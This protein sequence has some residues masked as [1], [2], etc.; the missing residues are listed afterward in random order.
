MKATLHGDFAI[1]EWL[2]SPAVNQISHD[3]SC[4]RVEPKAMQ[5]LV[6]LAEHPG[7]VSKAQLISAVW[8]D[9]F[10]SDDVL[11]GCISALRKAFDDNAR[12]PR[13]IETIHKSG[14]R[15][16]LPVEPISRNGDE[17]EAIA[18]PEGSW[19]RRV[20]S[21]RVPSAI[22]FASL[23]AVLIVVFA[24]A[25]SKPRYDSVAVLPF[26]NARD[27]HATQYL[28][29]GIAEQVVNDL[30][31][32]SSL[33]VMAWATVSRYRQPQVDARAVGRDLGVK[34]VLV[35]RLIREGDRIVLQTELVDV[36][37]GSR[38]WGQ[39]YE[40]NMSEI[41]QLQQQLS[42]DIASNLRVRLAGGEENKMLHRYSASPTA[43][44]L[45]L[46]GRFFWAKRTKQ[47]LQQGIDYFQQAISVDPNYASAY[48]GLADCYN[49]LDD[50]GETPPRESFPKARAAAD[51][52]IALDP[53][54]AEAHVS[55]AMV[56]GSYDWDW[57]GAEQEFKH[58]IELN[59]NYATAHQWYGI[60]LATLGRF[61]EAEA[62]VKRAQQL[63]P[64]SPII[65]MAVAE[66]YTWERR[67]DESIER[68][69]KVVELDPTF[70]VA[71]G[72]LSEVYKLKHLYGEELS[73]LQ[74]EWNL[75]GDPGFA[76][77]LERAYSKSGHLGVVREELKRVLEERARGQYAD[78]MS[79][80]GYYAE[81]GDE[82]AAFRWLQKGYEEHSSGMEFLGVAPDF[83]PLRSNTQFEYW[84]N[85]V[86]LPPAKA[87]TR[88]P[89]R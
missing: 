18:L 46:K 39:R 23:S 38:L 47:G 40:R 73:A 37:G 10:V 71:Y 79:I 6:Y 28:S 74:Q 65:N 83:D 64:L 12:R 62:E 58:A 85:V 57:V 15:L 63:D 45:Y 78:P 1:G 53:S 27:D 13:I 75:S 8:P 89:N 81:L 76:R 52:A 69:K 88:D 16:L 50:W 21:H 22:G 11:P 61:P 60:M 34:A 42:H 67:Y 14:Y 48:A 82:S 44:E 54:L 20:L 66:V 32:L 30:S 19:W 7:V 84:L 70:A 87:A 9:V 4:T 31:Q 59:P 17:G 86:G 56:R 35:G 43:Y 68:Y 2:V 80:A 49:L 29:D 24:W 55:L 5:V 3:G 77:L 41:A 26:L 25:F 72:N 33:R 51:K 36:G